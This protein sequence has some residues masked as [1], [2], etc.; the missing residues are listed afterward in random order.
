M[1]RIDLTKADSLDK[2]RIRF[3]VDVLS[4]RHAQGNGVA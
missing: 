1:A 3:I 2:V 4:L